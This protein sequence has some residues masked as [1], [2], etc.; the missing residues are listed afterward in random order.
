MR[1]NG[2]TLQSNSK[3]CGNLLGPFVAHFNST[4]GTLVGLLLLAPASI[5]LLFGISVVAR[6]FDSATIGLVWLQGVSRSNWIWQKTLISGAYVFIT[7]CL[8]ALISNA[9]GNSVYIRLLNP[10][11][12]VPKV[13]DINGVSIIGYTILAYGIGVL[14]GS[15][16]RRS[17]VGFAM[18]AVTFIIGR[19]AIEKLLRPLFEI[20]EYV[21]LNFTGGFTPLNSLVV[22]QGILPLGQLRP[23]V[24]HGF[25]LQ[26]SISNSC[27]LSAQEPTSG[28]VRKYVECLHLHGQHYV[29]EFIRNSQYWPA[30]IYEFGV[31]VLLVLIA[32]AG[33]RYI[34]KFTEI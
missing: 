33:A 23:G 16:A 31:C 19:L 7:A 12:L 1:A 32:I 8:I 22:N 3:S 24:G 11:P 18:G 34:L 13:F 9:W 20:K 17:G 29:V 5:G 6:E 14:A 28:Q 2:C 21:V 10:S 26:S 4:T 25:E 15:L 27:K 30:Q